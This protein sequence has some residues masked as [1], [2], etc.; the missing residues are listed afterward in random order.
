MSTETI[1]QAEHLS[2]LYRLGAAES[3]PET[4]LEAARS[5]AT[6]PWRNF[7]RLR[8]LDTWRAAAAGGAE[9]DAPDLLWALR[10]VSFAVGRGEVVGVVGRNGAGKSTLLK[11]LS[12]VTEPTAGRV[13]IRGRISSLLEVGTGFHPEMTGRENVYLNGTIL[14]MTK[15]EIDRKFG[16]IAEFSGVE[17][18]LDTPVKRY[19][20]GQRVRLAFAV[21]AH[22][23]P[24]VLIV[25]EVLAV[26]DQ[27]FQ[28]K[29]M[30]KMRDVAS[31]GSGRTV[32]FVSHNMAAVRNLCGR[33]VMLEGGRVHF[34]GDV[35][36]G[37][38]AYLDPA[39]RA[40]EDEDAGPLGKYLRA[41]RV[42]D[43]E[44]Q[45]VHSLPTG[46]ALVV[47]IDLDPGP[48]HA[49]HDVLVGFS[50]LTP[51]GDALAHFGNNLKHGPIP[52]VDRPMTFR[53]LVPSV[54]LAPGEFFIRAALAEGPQL[55]EAHDGA[56]RLTMVESDFFGSGRIYHAA[57]AA[58]VMPYD[59]ASGVDSMSRATAKAS[60]CPE[61]RGAA[62]F[63]CQT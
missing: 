25:D 3:R 14:G 59:W 4:L 36:A 24:E 47:E 20:S 61:T 52:V 30:G 46:E 10:D 12:R 2:K 53:C 19:S 28:R 1:I 6:A 31:A 57:L 13:R 50:F 44:G 18:F 8:G 45:P 37:I 51:G 9:S 23:E 15:R 34:D 39:R 21:A 40:R 33:V 54:T 48:G 42:L 17:R 56:A 55:L 62:P 22:L 49:L 16:E 35:E 60:A 26:G 32:L 7:R 43:P 27:E 63:F 29:C 38:E 5:I 11:I 58:V 41:V